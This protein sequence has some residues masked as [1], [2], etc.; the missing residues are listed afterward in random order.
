MNGDVFLARLSLKNIHK[1]FGD[2]RVIHGVDLDIA[3]G[4]FT[5]FVGPS[6]CG[7]STLLRMIAG[8]ETVTDGTVEIGGMD[9]S[10]ADP[11]DRGVTMVF[12]SYALYPHMNVYDNMAFSLK[13]NGVARD[14]IDTRVRR[15]ADILGLHDLLERKPKA[16]SGG[17][18][19]RVA[20]GRSIVREPK[21][22]LFDEPLSNLDA[23]LRVQMRLEIA[24]LHQDLG[25]TMIY[26]THD[27]VEA[28]TLA[29]KIVILRDGLIEQVGAPQTLYRDPDNMFVGGFIGSPRMNFLDGEI[30]GETGRGET[31]RGETGTSV[32][33][34]LAGYPDVTLSLPRARADTRTDGRVSVGIRPE[35]F[36]ATGKSSIDARIEVVENLG[37]TSYAYVASAAGEAM[38]VELPNGTEPQAGD[39]VTFHFNPAD[40]FLFDRDSGLRL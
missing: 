30:T 4:E 35:H 32:K 6:G 21:I 5:V 10:L 28:M 38:T 27:Q 16:L 26:V 17:Q 24:R 3:D 18:R 1:A 31:G 25:A 11:S 2:T 29:D 7:K 34:T 39:M 19:Q 9:V 8:L 36:A 22:F 15:A 20:I 12:Q 14:E 23:E 13:M 40:C 37:S 33:V